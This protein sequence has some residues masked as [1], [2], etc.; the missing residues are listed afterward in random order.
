MD[1][2]DSSAGTARLAVIKYSATVPNKRGTI[3]FNPGDPPICRPSS[4]TDTPFLQADLVVRESRPSSN[5]VRDSVKLLRA[6]TTWFPGIL[7]E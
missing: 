3:F 4:P 2:H 6:P 1:Y 5:S 7:G